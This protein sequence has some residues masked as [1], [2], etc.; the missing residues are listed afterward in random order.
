MLCWQSFYEMKK[1][2]KDAQLSDVLSGFPD[3]SFQINWQEY[4]NMLCLKE[5]PQ[6]IVSVYKRKYSLRIDF[7]IADLQKW[8]KK[9]HSHYSLILKAEPTQEVKLYL[10]DHGQKKIRDLMEDRDM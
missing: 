5:L 4:R 6:D 10:I 7:H 8:D 3:C 9:K 2:R 1:L